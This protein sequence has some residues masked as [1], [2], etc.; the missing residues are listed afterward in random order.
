M[1]SSCYQNGR[2]SSD[3]SRAI[4]SHHPLCRSPCIESILF[5]RMLRL[6]R[7]LKLDKYVPSITLVDDVFRLKKNALV[8]S[9]FAAGTLWILFAGLMYLVEYQDH[10]MDIDNLPL[11]GCYENCTMSNRYGSFL[12][13]LPLTGIHLT[14][15][16]P[17]VEYNGY[18]RI[19]CFVMVITAIGV[20]SIPSGLVASGFAEIVQSRVKSRS[21]E[22]T[23]AHIA[24]DGTFHCYYEYIYM[25]TYITLAQLKYLF[26]HIPP[27]W[28]TSRL[29]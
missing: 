29:V 6:L 21:N 19:V 10:S 25:L 4:L 16:F 24:G 14:G 3:I 9:C 22:Q 5:R 1:A 20:V 12:T 18:G 27:G 23:D 7:L 26:T 2:I 8:V 17:V 13:S 11:Y 28:N 15:D